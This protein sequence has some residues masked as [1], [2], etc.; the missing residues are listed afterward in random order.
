VK[1]YVAIPPRTKTTIA[2]KDALVT[3]FFTG[4]KLLALDVIPRETKSNQNYL[5]VILIPELSRGNT[6]ARSRVGNNLLLVSI[7][8]PRHHI[9]TKVS[10]ISTESQ[11]REFSILFIPRNDHRMMS[12]SSRAQKRK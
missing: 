3:I 11:R 1:S 7:D 8:S 5:L 9:H 4:T 12:G 6:N 2:P 10:S